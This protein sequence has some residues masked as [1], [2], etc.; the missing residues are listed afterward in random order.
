MIQ[1]SSAFDGGNIECDTCDDP[2]DIQLRIRQD[3]NAEFFQWFYFRLSG[4]KGRDCVMRLKNAGDASY[5]R[6]WEGYRAVAS[7]DREDWFRIETAYQDGELIL[8]HKPESNS[9]YYAYF[10]PYSMERHADLIARSA[11]SPRVSQSVLGKTA[12]GQ[13]VDLLTIGETGRDKKNF[14]LIA[15]QHPGETMAEW[16]MEGFLDR[17]RDPNDAVSN[18]LLD[19]ACFHVVPNMNPDGSRRGHLRTNAAGAN[20]NREWQEPDMERSPE[21]YLVRE[22]MRE[23]GV[24]FCLDVHGDEGLPH[25]FIAGAQGI[26]SWNAEKDR[27]LTDFKRSWQKINPDFQTR[28]GY[29]IPKKGAGNMT[30][31][32]NHVS[33]YF[34]CLAMTLEMPFKDTADRPDVKYGWSPERARKLGSSVLEVM[35]YLLDRLQSENS[36]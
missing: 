29:P 33:E 16:W 11:L 8:T 31:C 32:V 28:H 21:V 17:L 25:N 22:K 30:L 34:G 4:M 1:V 24:D 18:A 26:P 19:A 23:T 7:Y 10:A 20:L 9:V 36:N 13:D 15:R 12:D 3:T 35:F 6:G 2:L 5:V 27:L 14:W